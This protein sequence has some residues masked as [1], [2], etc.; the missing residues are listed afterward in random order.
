VTTKP[1]PSPRHAGPNDPERD[2][3]A[4]IIAHVVAFFH[5]KRK[6]DYLKAGE[7]LREL[8]R[9]GVVVKLRRQ[10]TAVTR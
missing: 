7:A 3:D 5:A 1:E 4:T 8:L 2:R 10:P 6:G 9:L